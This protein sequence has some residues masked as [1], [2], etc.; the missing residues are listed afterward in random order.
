M[1][2]WLGLCHQNK[3]R[4][5]F[6]C[7]PK[8]ASQFCSRAAASEQSSVDVQ[9]GCVVYFCEACFD[10]AKQPP[11]NKDCRPHGMTRSMFYKGWKLIAIVAANYLEPKFFSNFFRNF[12]WGVLSIYLEP[13]RGSKYRFSTFWGSK[14][15]LRTSKYILRTS[16]LIADYI[17]QNGT[18][19]CWTSY[20]EPLIFSKFDE[21]NK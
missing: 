19:P 17:P 13:Q 3:H 18:I 4:R 7:N 5:V 10:L 20:L 14:Y 8:P 16:G 2:K 21:T 6:W 1:G 9:T 12:F 15:I 11:R